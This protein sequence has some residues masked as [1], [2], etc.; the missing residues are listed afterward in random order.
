M[1][2]RQEIA[3]STL[4]RD[5]LCGKCLSILVM[6]WSEEEGSY[7]ECITCGRRVDFVKKATIEHYDKVRSVGAYELK[8]NPVF[9]RHL[10]AHMRPDVPDTETCLEELFEA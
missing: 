5:Y 7:V 1:A 8:H 4:C 2:A 10:S 3:D 9:A 6:R